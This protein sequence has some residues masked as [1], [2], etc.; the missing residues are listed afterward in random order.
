[1]LKHDNPDENECRLCCVRPIYL[2]SVAVWSNYQGALMSTT[3]SVFFIL[4]IERKNLLTSGLLSTMSNVLMGLG[5]LFFSS[6]VLFLVETMA[7]SRLAQIWEGVK[8]YDGE[9]EAEICGRF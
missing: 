3:T 2:R 6:E 9:K 8:D 4:Q 1:M 7:E 5:T